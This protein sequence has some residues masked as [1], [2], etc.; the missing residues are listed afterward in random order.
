MFSHFTN[1]KM[2]GSCSAEVKPGHSQM[3][4]FFTLYSIMQHFLQ[5]RKRNVLEF[6]NR[7]NDDAYILSLHCIG[8]NA[9]FKTTYLLF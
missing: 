2:A 3:F 7:V 6:K 4:K 5:S 8:K 9:L 1:F